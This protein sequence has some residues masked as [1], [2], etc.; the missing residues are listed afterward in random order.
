MYALVKFL[1]KYLLFVVSALPI[2]A[3]N[4]SGSVGTDFFDE[5]GAGDVLPSRVLLMDSVRVGIGCEYMIDNK[6]IIDLQRSTHRY[7]IFTM[8]GDSLIY[9]GDFM[10]IG[11]GPDEMSYPKFKYD[12]KSN[13]MFVYSLDNLED[14]FFV[15][16]MKDF[17]NIYNRA[18]WEKRRLPVVYTR[19]A[20]GI[21]SDTVFLNR[22]NSMNFNMFSLSY[23]GDKDNDARGVDFKY[24]GE[25]PGLS[26]NGQDFLFKGDM[27]KNPGS[28]TFVY[29]CYFSQYVF[30]FDV[31]DKQIANI[32]YISKILPVYKVR[33]DLYNPFGIADQYKRGFNIMRVTDRY[34]YIGYNNLTWGQ[35]RNMTGYKGYPDYYF[36]RINVFDWDGNFVKRL[37]LDK[38]VSRFVVDKDDHYICASTIDL[39]QEDQPD[40]ILRFEMKK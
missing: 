8:K 17:K 3:C 21:L 29:S 14:K 31:V 32:R 12:R 11:K 1:E 24:P 28:L 16:D 34:I 9:E 38:P 26:C 36:D 15:I 18:S 35:I 19:S 7:E 6:L 39:A 10:Q 2:M 20:L 4:H 23:T 30:I 40:Q 25:H 37:V 22:S 33:D 27:E 13:R 5:N